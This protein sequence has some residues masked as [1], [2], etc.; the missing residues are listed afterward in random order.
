MQTIAI[1]EWQ[2]RHWIS[3]GKIMTKYYGLLTHEKERKLRFSGVLNELTF[4]D[5]ARSL[6][7]VVEKEQMSR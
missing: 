3:L 5:K 7:L 4:E 1:I 2:H 6:L